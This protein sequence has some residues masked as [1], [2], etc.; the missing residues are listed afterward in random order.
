MTNNLLQFP[1]PSEILSKLPALV[2][3]PLG[4]CIVTPDGEVE[5]YDHQELK[6]IARDHD[7]LVCNLPMPYK[8][9]NLSQHQT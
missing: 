5:I 8:M 2:V 4:G 3:G 1:D 6:S 7:F 9:Q